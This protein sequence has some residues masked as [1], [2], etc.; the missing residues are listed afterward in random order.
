MF[1]DSYY[2][3]YKKNSKCLF[4]AAITTRIKHDAQ[5]KEGFIRN[6]RKTKNNIISSKNSNNTLTADLSSFAIQHL[7]PIYAQAAITS[8]ISKRKVNPPYFNQNWIF[9]LWVFFS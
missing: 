8:I 3:D 6:T 4:R 5:K 9:T 1:S 2:D 7:Q